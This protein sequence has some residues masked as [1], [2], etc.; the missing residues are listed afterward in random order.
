M[1]QYNMGFD[2][3]NAGVIPW[4][5]RSK[6]VYRMCMDILDATP[7]LS[8][9]GPAFERP[10]WSVAWA[11]EA[12]VM[13]AEEFRRNGHFKNLQQL[14]GSCVGLGATGMAFWS[15]VTDAIWTGDPTRVLFPF[16]G[17]HYGLG[18][19]ESGIRGQGEG[20]TGSGQAAA[21][22]KYGLLAWDHPNVPRPSLD[23]DTIKWTRNVELIWS[24]G[25]GPAQQ[26]ITEGSKNRFASI[27]KCTSVEQAIDLMASR[28]W[29]TQAS[30]WGGIDGAGIVK[31]TGNSR[32]L[33]MPRRTVWNHQ[34]A[35]LGYWFHPELDLQI[36]IG[37]QWGYLHGADPDRIED[38][39]SP[40][41]AP[42]GIFWIDRASFEWMLRSREV[43]FFANMPN[44]EVRPG[45]YR[46]G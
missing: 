19:L 32:I 33:T 28:Y 39:N 25:N 18:R 14:T 27:T 44:F 2:P 23:T 5:A 17:Y 9:S 8:C 3:A 10:K 24:D 4:G 26:L 16:F 29:G 38:E 7:V 45:K 12:R 20:S 13:M 36:A 42:P 15:S 1:S 6:E 31:G 41:P 11:G 35:V 30:D 22:D 40:P 34:M 46:M 43:F 21:L 37:N